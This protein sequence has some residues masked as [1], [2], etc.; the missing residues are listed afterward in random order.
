MAVFYLIVFR[1]FADMVSIMSTY[2]R[3]KLMACRDYKKTSLLKLGVQVNCLQY[4]EIFHI[5]E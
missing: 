4:L 1:R 3:L 5:P 2:P